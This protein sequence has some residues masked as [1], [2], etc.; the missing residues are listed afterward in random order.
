MKEKIEAM[1]A[2]LDKAE[3]DVN[4]FVDAGNKSA[5]ARA[6][7]SMQAIKKLAQEIR[8]G[9]QEAKNAAKG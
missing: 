6:R 7:K 4:L 9:V 1:R 2:E 3:Q 5:G 8:T